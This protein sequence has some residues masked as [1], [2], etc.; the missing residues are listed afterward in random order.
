MRIPRFSAVALFAACAALVACGG[1]A[2]TAKDLAPHVSLLS[3]VPNPGG[4]LDR[5]AELHFTFSAPVDWAETQFVTCVSGCRASLVPYRFVSTGSEVVGTPI[6]PP[7]FGASYTL[8]ITPLFAQA[9]ANGDLGANIDFAW[10]TLPAT[11]TVA[12]DV[13]ADTTLSLAGSPYYFMPGVLVRAALTVEPGV[14]VAGDLVAAGAGSV[15]AIGTP[16]AHVRISNAVFSAPGRLSYVD[17]PSAMQASAGDVDHSSIYCGRAPPGPEALTVRISGSLTDSRVTGCVVPSLHGQIARNVFSN[18]MME[19]GA[20]APGSAF[21]ASGSNGGPPPPT[22]WD[23]STSFVNNY[24][25]WSVPAYGGNGSGYVWL[26]PG[27]GA[28]GGNTFADFVPGS[29]NI[30]PE[31]NT[32]A[33]DLSGNYWDGADAATVATY[34]R[35]GYVLPM[36][37][38][39]VFVGPL[40]PPPSPT[41]SPMLAAPDPATPTP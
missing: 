38:G 32:T 35:T 10:S 3:T 30:Y 1:S 41:P 18:T 15:T 11:T 2:P 40:P 20:S 33:V 17:M 4:G 31:N 7:E 13:T 36:F 21:G 39:G 5:W 26:T 25:T 8:R 12:S 22:P 27:A 24:L 6:L 29:W 16:T 28:I 14:E 37:V 19:L 23:A 34:F 9:A